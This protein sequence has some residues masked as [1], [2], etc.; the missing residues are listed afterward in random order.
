MHARSLSFVRGDALVSSPFHMCCHTN[1]LGSRCAAKGKRG[2]CVRVR[3]CV[4]A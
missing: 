4:C 1:V 3:V 2:V